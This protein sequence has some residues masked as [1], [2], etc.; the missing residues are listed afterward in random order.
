MNYGLANGIY[1]NKLEGNAT[2]IY[3]NIRTGLH[4][5]VY[6]ENLILN[7]IVKNG[8]ILYLDFKYPKSYSRTGVLIKDLSIKNNNGT[9]LNG[10]TFNSETNSSILF[11]GVDDYISGNIDNITEYTLCTFIKII[12][13]KVGGGIIGGT[14][15][16]HPYIQMGVSNVWQFNAAISAQTPTINQ[17]VYVTAVQSTF[18]SNNQI[19][20]LNGIQ[21]AIGTGTSILGNSY[22][23]ARREISAIY[24]NC[25][26][27]L[28]KIYNRALTQS[29]INQNYQAIKSR[30]NL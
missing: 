9:I 23:L 3:D 25:Q 14:N 15:L 12:T 7:N 19:L 10:A 28:A 2:G 11:D 16:N 1:T 26:I 18:A 24:T 4:N 8:L 6:N 13:L 21:N 27:G 5:G 17:W 20:Y 22:V 30:F 29:E